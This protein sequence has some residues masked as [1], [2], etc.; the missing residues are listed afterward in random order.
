MVGDKVI[1]IKTKQDTFPRIMVETLNFVN[2]YYHGNYRG[3]PKVVRL[4]TKTH[5]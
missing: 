4:A 5:L 1:K 3:M 2:N